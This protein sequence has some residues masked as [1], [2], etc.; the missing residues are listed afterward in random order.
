MADRLLRRSSF[1][2]PR[3][4]VLLL[5]DDWEETEMTPE[6]RRMLMGACLVVIAC[7]W[8]F[9]MKEK[10]AGGTGGNTPGTSAPAGSTKP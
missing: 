9:S 7:L 4:G 6:V 2:L 8:Y 10:P 5:R 1:W 3:S